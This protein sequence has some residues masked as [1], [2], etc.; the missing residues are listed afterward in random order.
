MAILNNSAIQALSVAQSVSG[1]VVSVETEHLVDGIPTIGARDVLTTVV[2]DGFD[3]VVTKEA[4]GLTEEL[5]A[6]SDLLVVTADQTFAWSQVEYVDADTIKLLNYPLDVS[7]ITGLAL[8]TADETPEL[9]KETVGTVTG[10]VIE[11]DGAVDDGLA[12]SALKDGE[13]V[14]YLTTTGETRNE[15]GTA[16]YDAETNT[17]NQIGSAVAITGTKIEVDPIFI[18]TPPP[19]VAPPV[20][21]A[22]AAMAF[23]PEATLILDAG[24]LQQVAM[25]DQVLAGQALGNDLVRAGINH[26]L[27]GTVATA[28]QIAVATRLLTLSRAVSNPGDLIIVTRT[29]G[30]SVHYTVGFTQANIQ[31][32]TRAAALR[33]DVVFTGEQ[34]LA[35]LEATSG[36]FEG[37]L[38]QIC[39]TFAL[40]TVT[41]APSALAARIRLG[42]RVGGAFLAAGINAGF[43]ALGL[44]EAIPNNVV[45]RQG[46]MQLVN[47][48]AETDEDRNGWGSKIYYSP[49]NLD[50][51][52]LAQ[53]TLARFDTA[54]GNSQNIPYRIVDAQGNVPF[55]DLSQPSNVPF[56][57]DPTRL[58]SQRAVIAGRPVDIFMCAP[59]E[60]PDGGLVARLRGNPNP[61]RALIYE[62][63]LATVQAAGNGGLPLTRANEGP[64]PST[65][66]QLPRMFY[67]NW[68]SSTARRVGGI[69]HYLAWDRVLGWVLGS[70]LNTEQV[71]LDGEVGWYLDPNQRLGYKY[72]YLGSALPVTARGVTFCIPGHRL[73]TNMGTP[74]AYSDYRR[75]DEYEWGLSLLAETS[76]RYPIKPDGVFN[77]WIHQYL[78]PGTAHCVRG[79]SGTMNGFTQPFAGKYEI[80]LCGGYRTYVKHSSGDTTMVYGGDNLS[81][82]AGGNNNCSFVGVNMQNINLP[83]GIANLGGLNTIRVEAMPPSIGMSRTRKD[84]FIG[85]RFDHYV[86]TASTGFLF[87]QQFAD[88]AANLARH[89]NANPGNLAV[90][91]EENFGPIRR[92]IVKQFGFTG[93]C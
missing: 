35:T 82:T 45:W 36:T 27:R 81:A 58:E 49:L 59:A 70:A 51:P 65:P 74:M 29:G 77:P 26:G 62:A 19:V 91:D 90:E 78:N 17:L 61:T 28:E 34:L 12:C 25:N 13:I 52:A 86:Y 73:L 47:R 83:A 31:A 76:T 57:Y 22:A 84:R 64:L 67:L 16:I 93:T 75:D 72:L 63:M 1:T 6:A 69:G 39:H 88:F 3:A 11:L 89:N 21:P 54:P 44:I 20:V 55:V 68:K 42:A 8:D 10:T 79:A 7:E 48:I 23:N 5:L 66:A 50:N 60:N 85:S 15:Y 33:G 32:L 18:T 53:V 80:G 43:V 92:R 2:L 87:H 38:E 9:I 71:E 4:H 30:V 40:R 14:Q 24:V 46:R 56:R 37:F 41:P